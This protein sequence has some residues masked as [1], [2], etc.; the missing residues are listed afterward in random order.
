M[1]YAYYQYFHDKLLVMHGFF[2]HYK[3]R[4]WRFAP[5]ICHVTPRCLMLN[6]GFS[7]AFSI[8]FIRIQDICGI[9]KFY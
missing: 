5:T 8:N 1:E 6:T 9:I 7:D 2:K 3:N 4:A